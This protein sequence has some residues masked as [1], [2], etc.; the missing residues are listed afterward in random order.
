MVANASDKM[1]KLAAP[2]TRTKTGM[3]TSAKIMGARSPAKFQTEFANILLP[4][5]SV[6]GA[7]LM[8]S[9]AALVAWRYI[10]NG[11]I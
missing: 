6:R 7:E 3:L 4:V 2:S 9:F 1:P 10:K 11:S 8:Q 5:V